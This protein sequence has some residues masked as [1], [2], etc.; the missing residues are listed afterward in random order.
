VFYSSK[1]ILKLYPIAN[2]ITYDK[3][4]DVHKWHFSTIMKIVERTFYHKVVSGVNWKKAMVKV[5]EAL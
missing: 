4:L 5:I 2:H 3:F 1:G